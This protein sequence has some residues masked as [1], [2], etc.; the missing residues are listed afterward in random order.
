MRRYLYALIASVIAL[1]PA[2]AGV[3]VNS[4]SFVAGSN[5]LL[6][7]E[8]E[9]FAIDATVVGG[10]VSIRDTGTPANNL[11]NV[12][13]TSA[14]ITQSSASAKVVPWS[15]GTLRTVA[16]GS[17]P[18][19]WDAANSRFGL[20]IEKAAT[21]LVL[22]S[23]EF[24]NASWSQLNGTWDNDATTAPD[25]TST[26]DQWI[27]DVSGGAAFHDVSQT[28]ITTT[29]NTNY[30]Y[31]L[32][33]KPG[34]GAQRSVNMCVEGATGG[35]CIG[36]FN[37]T[38]GTFNFAASSFGSGATFI[39]R[40]STQLANG[41]WLVTMTAENADASSTIYAS[42]GAADGT[43]GYQGDGTSGIYYW[44][45]QLE[46]GDSA[47]SY[48]VTAGASATRDRDDIQV[49]TSSIPWDNTKGTIYADHMARDFAGDMGVWVA[50]K[51]ADEVVTVVYG[52][53]PL[54]A[55]FNTGT[56]VFIDA[57]THAAAYARAQITGAFASGDFDVSIDGGAAVTNTPTLSGGYTTLQ[58]GVDQQ[59]ANLKGF[60]YRF[61]YVPRQVETDGNNIET[62][63]YNF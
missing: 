54:L 12:P 44:G 17:L 15:D 59:P 34:P 62:W 56:N 18:Q 24:D 63:R 42:P 16:A 60:L 45:A 9:G 52:P 7:G 50:V 1:L 6:S 40:T 39:G 53:E 35:S 57:G 13:F 36:F 20:L 25:G 19:A 47:S 2:H 30:T 32:Y 48:I 37:P 26:A 29:A 49:T 38:T 33:I 8:T 31:S 28:S 3:L 61:V 23:Q 58:L 21:N 11:F 55:N 27:E 14:N 43:Y 10:S 46:R 5:R 41:W 51:D 4:Y 22:R